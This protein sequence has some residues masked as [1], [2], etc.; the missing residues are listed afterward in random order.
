MAELL[1]IFQIKFAIV[2]CNSNSLRSLYGMMM[3]VLEKC[4]FFKTNPSMDFTGGM[5]I[6]ETSLHHK[7][8]AKSKPTTSGN[9]P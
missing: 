9:T 4:F 1:D 7:D 5:H 3:R 2:N 8:A 6:W